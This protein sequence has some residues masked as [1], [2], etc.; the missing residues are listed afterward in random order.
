LI[1]LLTP[2]FGLKESN[3]FAMPFDE[4]VPVTPDACFGMSCATA[5][6]GIPQVLGLF[7]LGMSRFCGKSY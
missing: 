7:D 1:V 3:Y 4:R 6:L 5:L 2:P